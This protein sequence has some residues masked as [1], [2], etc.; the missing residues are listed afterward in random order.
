MGTKKKHSIPPNV[1]NKDLQYCINQYVRNVEHRKMLRDWWFHNYTLQELSYKYHV[2]LT[3]T[4]NII[5]GQGDGI[6]S[7][8]SQMTT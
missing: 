3:T 1:Q 4:K 2:S 5:Y 8:A 7:I 6:L